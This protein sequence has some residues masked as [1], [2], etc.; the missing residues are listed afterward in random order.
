MITGNGHDPATE[1]MIE[2]LLRMANGLERLNTQVDVIHEDMQA[3]R[4]DV[5]GIR[6]E[7]RSLSESTGAG[8]RCR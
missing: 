5:T 7:I 4:A 3:I 2:V 8:K 1:Q 6:N